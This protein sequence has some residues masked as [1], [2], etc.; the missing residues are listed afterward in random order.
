MNTYNFAVNRPDWTAVTISEWTIFKYLTCSKSSN[1][2][3]APDKKPP[4]QKPPWQNPLN[5]KPPWIIEQIIAKYAVDDNLF[6]LGSTN[7]KKI[8]PLVFFG[9]LYRG[10][11]FGG[12]WPKTTFFI[13]LTHLNNS[14]DEHQMM[15]LLSLLFLFC[16]KDK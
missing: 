16:Y 1:R 12:F 7:P 8:Q 14:Y 13:A 6:R 2:S 4:G 3:K 10:L 11:I 9:L 5:N 15:F